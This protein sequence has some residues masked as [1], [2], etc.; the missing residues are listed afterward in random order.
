MENH[1][2]LAKPKY[3]VT[4]HNLNSD[5]SKGLQKYSTIPFNMELILQSSDNSA[6]EENRP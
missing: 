4:N 1:C 5:T 3:H 2:P 6:V